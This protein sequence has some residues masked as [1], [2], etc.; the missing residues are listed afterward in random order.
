[1]TH[2][3]RRQQTD[4][5]DGE[6][7][8]AVTQE[9]GLLVALRQALA[10]QREGV[11]GGDPGAV[12][13]ASHRVAHAVMNLD[14]ARR[15]REAL[16]LSFSHARPMRLETLELHVGP[17]PGLAEAR[18]RLREEAEETLRDLTVT[19]QVLQAALRAGDAYLQSLFAS[20]TDAY[21]ETGSAPGALVNRRA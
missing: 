1:M 8:H 12:E 4:D 20:V 15:K 13:A 5:R 16:V 3:D 17:V 11:A 10:R 9:H 7:V 21:H 19:Q 18:H 6:L 2:S 14:E